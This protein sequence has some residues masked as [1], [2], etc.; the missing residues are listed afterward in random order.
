MGKFLGAI[1]L[2]LFGTAAHAADGFYIGASLGKSSVDHLFGS[3]FNLDSSTASW[4]A[5][6]GVRPIPVFAVEAN[7]LDFG[8]R[9]RN[10]GIGTASANARAFAAYGVGF[11]PLPFFDVFAKAG[12]ARWQL[13]GDMNGAGQLFAF[14]DHG[15]QFAYGGG[16]QANWG[17]FSARFEY[18]G[19]QIR[20]T[21]GLKMYTLG[22]T[23]T[24]L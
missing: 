1:A 18:D 7:Y 3:D 14:D 8:S 15:T 17:P 10:F 5:I 12:A 19:F 2:A 24:F 21:D 16:V 13:R 11:L 22:A 23:W 20:N 4:K 6:A 9:S